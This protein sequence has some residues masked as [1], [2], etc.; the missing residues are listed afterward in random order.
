MMYGSFHSSELEVETT[1]KVA[2]LDDDYKLPAGRIP[3]VHFQVSALA[4]GTPP[5]S[6][7]WYI[8]AR[9]TDNDDGVAPTVTYKKFT[10]PTTTN[11]VVDATDTTKAMAV[12]NSNDLMIPDIPDYGE[13]ME[14][15]ILCDSGTCTVKATIG[16][17]T[18]MGR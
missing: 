5:A 10:E 16:S 12:V 2:L 14:I 8:H 13:P 3:C 15:H 4:G 18:R 1:Y 11:L 17:E 6:L 9:D 7:T